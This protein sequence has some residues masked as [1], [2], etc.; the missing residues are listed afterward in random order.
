[1]RSKVSCLLCAFFV[2][3]SCLKDDIGTSN[4]EVFQYVW[5]ELDQQYGGFMARGVNWD[6]MYTALYP[7]AV[8]SQTELE[9]FAICSELIDVLDDQ[10]VSIV[11]ML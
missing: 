10:H 1:M 6:S 7:S 5:D 4:Q 3:S 11:L 9:I 8:A 2:F